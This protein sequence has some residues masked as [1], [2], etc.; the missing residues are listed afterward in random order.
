M[1]LVSAVSPCSSWPRAV[2]RCVLG[3]A[4]L[5]AGIAHLTTARVAFRAQVPRW[6]PVEPDLVVVA[7]GVV[8]ILLGLALVLLVR[9]QVLVG[10]LAAVFFVV[11]FPGN[12]AQFV[13]RVDGF[14][15]DTDLARALRLLGQPVLVAWALW[16]GGTWAWWREHRADRRDGRGA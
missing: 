7:S 8:E 6:F 2:G 11:V 9:R 5:G 13:D 1:S 3:L 16:A 14:G 15:L 10:A 12:I 4:V